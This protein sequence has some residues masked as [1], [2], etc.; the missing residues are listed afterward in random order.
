LRILAALALAALSGTPAAPAEKTYDPGASDS[1][2]LLGYIGSDAAWASAY[3]VVEQAEAAYFRMV[4]DEGGISGRRIR[5]LTVSGGSEASGALEAARQL[6]DRDGVLLVFSP[7]GTESNLAIRGYLNER[8][9]PQLFVESRSAAF[10]DPSHFPWTMGFFATD[11]IEGRLYAAFILKEKPGGRIAVLHPDNATGKEFLEG[12]RA[13]LGDRASAMIVKELAYRSDEATIE[14]QIRA[15]QATGADVFLN[16]TLGA[17]VTEAIRTA[18]DLDWHPLQ[19]IPNASLSTAAFLDPAGLEKARGIIANA[20]SKS[21]TGLQAQSD[22]AVRVFLSWMSKYNPDASLRDQNYVAGY[23]R[24][25]AMVAVLRKCGDDLTRANVMKQA[26]SLD[27]EL[28]MLRPGIRVKTSPSDYQPIKQLFLIRFNGRSRT[29][30]G[31]VV[32]A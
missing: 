14:P 13:G 8:K 32:G 29:P 22:P 17:F 26:A 11:K 30:V 12:V 10:D 5:L 15:L 19:F 23:E 2:I 24:A 31:P 7:I 9:V 18:Y 16:L 28:G 3:R 6:V 25:Q 1:E 21:W 20:R 4:N 27:L